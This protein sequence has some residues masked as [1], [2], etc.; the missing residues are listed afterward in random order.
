MI[1]LGLL[2]GGVQGVQGIS[3]DTAIRVV[4]PAWSIST[5][6][7]GPYGENSG[8]VSCSYDGERVAVGYGAGIVEIR[9]RQGDPIGRWQ[10]PQGYYSVWSVRISRDGRRVVAILNDPM[11]ENKGQI[12]YLNESGELIWQNPL[13]VPFGF[14][15]LSDDGSVV[16][17][18]EGDR[19]SFY[20]RSGN[21]TGTKVLEGMIWN[22]ALAGDGS[23]AVAGVTTRDY[24]GNLYVIGNDGTVEWFSTTPGKLRA[25]AVSGNGE[26]LAGADPEQIRFF[27]RNG[28]RIWKFNSSTA[29]TSLA[30]SS[31]G[32]Y[33]A[34]GAQYYLRYFNREGE[35]VWRYDDPV[36]ATRTGAYFN[37]VAITKNGE[38]VATTTRENRTLLFTNQGEVM[39]VF[40][41][42]TWVT[43]M[44]MT[45]SGN[46]IVIGT[47]PEI[48]YFD[49]GISP[50]PDMKP[51][52]VTT[53]TAPEPT[54]IPSTTKKT[55]VSVP[56]ILLC[57]VI[58]AFITV[59]F[60]KGRE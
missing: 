58:V 47:G 1:F 43:D 7:S 33:V 13:T 41:S 51:A 10:S 19:I 56:D 4:T 34:A 57:L 9:N 11:Q 29:V 23:Y 60:G 35:V 3:A 17:V 42:D 46:A 37:N 38:F 2:L 20:D 36:M 21:R 5:G 39:S 28:S 59:G 49:T 31:G 27:A 30:I 26:Y 12:V 44:C 55:P 6:Y 18:T 50:A 48:R 15:D 14:V 40:E 8:K 24:S 16:T 52:P 54:A 25:T 53:T 32:E 45:G 22:M